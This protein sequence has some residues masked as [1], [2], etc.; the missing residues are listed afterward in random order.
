MESSV[1]TLESRLRDEAC[2]IKQ[3]L[4]LVAVSKRNRRP[5]CRLR[6]WLRELCDLIPD[7]CCQSVFAVAFGTGRAAFFIDAICDTTRVRQRGA[8]QQTSQTPAQRV[9]G[10][11]ER[12]QVLLQ[13]APHNRSL[14][15]CACAQTPSPKTHCLGIAPPKHT[16]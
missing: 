12:L 3:Y 7:T 14:M 13:A 15:L 11:A 1:F 9:C 8:Q 4:M 5:G 10:F 2:C 16:N 6:S